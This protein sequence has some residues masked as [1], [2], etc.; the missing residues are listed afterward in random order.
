MNEIDSVSGI[1]RSIPF[2]HDS[3]RLLVPSDNLGNLSP[4][5]GIFREISPFPDIIVRI[6]CAP[7]VDINLISEKIRICIVIETVGDEKIVGFG[8]LVEFL[9]HH[10]EG[11]NITKN[12]LSD[13]IRII[14]RIY[15]NGYPPFDNF[16]PF[17][18]IIENVSI[19]ALAI[20]NLLL[21]AL[22]T[23]LNFCSY[24]IGQELVPAVGNSV[25]CIRNDF[26]PLGGSNV[27]VEL[28]FP[29]KTGVELYRVELEHRLHSPS[30]NAKIAFFRSK[31]TGKNSQIG[32][33]KY[34]C[35][36]SK[37]DIFSNENEDFFRLFVFFQ[38]LSFFRI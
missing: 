11:L 8:N 30:G 2:V 21:Q 15:R 34:A 13:N 25:R 27:V 29:D 31:S 36:L 28:E 5:L 32:I 10:F 16:Q 18:W 37:Y 9:R 38:R 24:Y 19:S 17:S 26:F 20:D 14:L 3:S 35:K 22:D 23:Q 1:V 7:F 6:F 33:C 12:F 4:M